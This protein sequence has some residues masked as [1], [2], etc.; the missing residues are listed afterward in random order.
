MTILPGS[1][2]QEV[3]HNL[4]CAAKGG[5]RSLASALPESVLPWRRSSHGR[6]ELAAAA[7]GSPGCHR[8]LRASH[9]GVDSSGRMLHGRLGLGL[10]G[11]AVSR[12]ADS[13]ATIGSAISPTSC[14]ASSAA[15]YITLVNLL[16]AKE[17]FPEHVND[18]TPISPVP[19]KSC[20]RNT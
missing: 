10:A 1:R 13:D 3:E 11:T 20:F 4:P 18:T 15:A 12:Q 2:T 9:A 17:L 16:T 14:R 7:A 5:G 6:Q 19:S 8:S